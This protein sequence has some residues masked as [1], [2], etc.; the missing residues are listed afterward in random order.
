MNETELKEKVDSL[1]EFMTPENLANLSD[2]ELEHLN[3]LL[4]KIEEIVE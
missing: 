4:D 3:G 2:E 1:M